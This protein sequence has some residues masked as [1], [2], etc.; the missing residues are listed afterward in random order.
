MNRLLRILP[1][2]FSG[3]VVIGLVT[4]PSYTLAAVSVEQMIESAKTKADHEN[5][6]KYYENAANNLKAQAEQ[7]KKMSVSYRAMSVGK[8][9]LGGFVAH[10]EKLVAKYEALAADNEALAKLHHQFAEKLDQ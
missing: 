1:V 5:L 8:G 6:A 4:S 2:I 10:C 3:I 9:G 7:H